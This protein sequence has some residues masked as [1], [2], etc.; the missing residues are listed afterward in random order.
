MLP[1]GPRTKSTLSVS[2][3]PAIATATKPACAPQISMTWPTAAAP[4]ATPPA[5]PVELH[6]SAS[7]SRLWSTAD[8]VTPTDAINVGAIAMPLRMSN[9][10]TPTGWLINGRGNNDKASRVAPTRKRRAG[11]ACHVIAPVA[12]PA[13]SEPNDHAIKIRPAYGSTP[14]AFA[15][16]TILTS[17]PPKIIP[18][19]LQAIATG[20]KTR[21]GIRV[22]PS[23][24]SKVERV[25]GWVL[26]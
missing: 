6:A 8:W 15:N 11:D 26:R 1:C 5:K 18:R 13:T 22:H 14:A 7:V 12:A 4:I 25:G 10:A 24:P 19:A 2:N 9:A 16:A 23:W 21:H 3:S 17:M 20:S